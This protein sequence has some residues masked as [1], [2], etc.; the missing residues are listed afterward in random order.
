MA[1]LGGTPS[2]ET[3]SRYSCYHVCLSII[4]FGSVP[5]FICMLLIWEP[6]LMLNF[7]V[8]SSAGSLNHPVGSTNGLLP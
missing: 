5:R 8:S 4:A 7:I 3:F 1:L 2:A 6:I